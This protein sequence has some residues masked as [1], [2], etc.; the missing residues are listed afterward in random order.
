MV[1][2]HEI[3]KRWNQHQPPLKYMLVCETPKIIII[4]FRY[5][6][7]QSPYAGAAKVGCKQTVKYEK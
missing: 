6:K 7:I 1:K 5:F 4:L 2:G 3:F